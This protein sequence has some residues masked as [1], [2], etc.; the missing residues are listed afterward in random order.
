LPY[1]PDAEWQ[2][3]ILSFGSIYWMDEMPTI[4]ELLAKQDDMLIILR[5][6]GIRLQLWDGE[7]LSAQD[8]HLWNGVKDQVPHWALF[9]RLNLNDEQKE[10]RKK[11][12]RQVE[13]EFECLSDGS[14]VVPDE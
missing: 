13:E 7:V 2:V 8:Q 14:D 5:M 1:R 12:E 10:V 11:A 6:F 3:N 9:R 4:G